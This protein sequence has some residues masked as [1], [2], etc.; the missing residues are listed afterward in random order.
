M[1]KKAIFTI[2]TLIFLVTTTA[3]GVILYPERQGQKDGKID[4][5]VAFL[6]GVGLLLFIVPG[7]VAFAVDFHQGTI[8]LPNSQ[9]AI[10]A[11][12]G[13]FREVRMDGP[14]TKESIEAILMQELGLPIDLDHEQAIV[15]RLDSLQNTAYPQMAYYQT[16]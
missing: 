16:K 14:I 10:D 4:L 12:E 9:S 11:G 2:S 5:S 8:Y 3:C 7:L 6:D 1:L 13:E 15:T